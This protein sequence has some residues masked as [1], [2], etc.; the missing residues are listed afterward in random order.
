M[1]VYNF[2][3]KTASPYE[4]YLKKGLYMFEAWGAAGI[5]S[6]CEIPY[7]AKG[8]GAYVN[9]VIKL[10]KPKTFYIYVGG[11]GQSSNEAFNGNMPSNNTVAGGG[12]TDFRTEKGQWYDIN[13]LKSRI[14]V[15]A[16]GGG[17]DC[18]G[19]GD[20]GT[21]E[22]LPP[23]E[24]NRISQ[25]PTGATQT[26][27]GE[28]GRLTDDYT[29]GNS[30]EFGVGGTGDI[31]KPVYGMLDG[32]GNG[33]GGYFGG[34]GVTGWGG[35]SGGSSFVSGHYGCNAIL[36]DVDG[37]IPSNQSI[38][39]SGLFFSSSNMIP[40][41]SSMPDPLSN[42]EGLMIGNSKSGYARI[43]ELAVYC[44]QNQCQKIPFHYLFTIILS[45]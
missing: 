28:G 25:N 8:R 13:S 19:G 17:N 11:M 40:G 10:K 32:G 36:G 6:I 29:F 20:G 14:M 24:T 22:G 41:N 15:A 5:S 31:L 16:G 35:G 33:G 43:T 21:F 27:G 26:K 7:E 44:T 34:G 23:E 3:F 42:E 1:K 18:W 37:I 12:A 30:G 45:S 4:I 2:P 38:H 39:Y 9:G